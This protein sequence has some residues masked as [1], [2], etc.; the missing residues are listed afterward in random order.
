MVT[1]VDPN[2]I[3]LTGE[4]S[5]IRLG[6]QEGAPYTTQA[7]HWRI[8]LSPA[9][10]GHALF[11]Q[12]DVTDNQVRIYSDNIQLARWLQEELEVGLNAAFADLNTP[13]AEATF[14]REGDIRSYST[15]KVVSR[16]ADISLTWYDIGEPFLLRLAPESKLAH[17]LVHGMYSVLTPA[18][19]AQLVL[20]GRTARGRSLRRC[21]DQEQHSSSCCL[22]WSETWL[23]SLR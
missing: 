13:V 6:D 11:L 4:N 21:A 10:P 7:S 8:L 16:D 15:Q 23:R 14:S 12:S 3:R 19:N 18:N 17:K 1:P 9:G 22:A 2:Q 5:F 20:N